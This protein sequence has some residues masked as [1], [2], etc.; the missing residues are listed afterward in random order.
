MSI[1]KFYLGFF[2]TILI[3]LLV[4]LTLV[5]EKPQQD[6]EAILKPI[7]EQVKQEKEKNNQEITL[8]INNNVHNAFISVYEKIPAFTQTQY[9][10]YHDYIM[11]YQIGKSKTASLW[12]EW[13]Y[14]VRTSIWHDKNVPLPTP[15]I[16]EYA[17]KSFNE[18]K[19][20]LFGNGEFE[21]QIEKI[22]I[23]AHTE[24]AKLLDQ[25]KDTILKTINTQKIQNLNDAN[26]AKIDE[27]KKEI[28][29]AFVNAHHDLIN[30]TIEKGGVAGL[31]LLLTKSIT[32]KLLAKSGIKLGAKAGGFL[33]GASTGITLCAPSG[34][35]AL[36][37]G[38]AV[39]SATW[40]GV[41]FTVSKVDEAMN[42]EEFEK[43]LK[44]ELEALEKKYKNDMENIFYK[45]IEATYKT[46]ENQMHLSPIEIITKSK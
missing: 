17:Q 42:K 3:L 9:T 22:Y 27:L 33:T 5:F 30:A 28:E 46:L 36:L 24:M 41:D 45:G 38:V 39:G 20:V 2:G 12:Q 7:Q 4:S 43:T 37:C 10:W 44:Q 25:S 13:S 35:W 31:G 14:F 23:D 34:P 11:I 18:V 32:T 15:K 1:D 29:Y 40:I 26:L 8:F 6:I 21:Q 19:E 16:N